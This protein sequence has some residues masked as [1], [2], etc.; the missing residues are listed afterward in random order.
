M[1]LLLFLL[2]AWICRE[3]F[4]IEFIRNLDSNEGVFVSISRFFRENFF[5]QRWYP[6]FNCGMPIENAYQPLLPIWAAATGW[7]TGWSVERAFHFVLAFAYCLG[8]VGLFL[9]A[10]EWSASMVTGVAAGLLYSLT[11]YAQW[12]IPILRI[13]L[14]GHWGPLRLY[15][16]VHY[17]EDPHNV[18]LSLL[19]FALLF[20]WRL[21][22]GRRT[23]G[24]FA[25][26]IVFSGA[27]VATNAFGAVDLAIGALCIILA[28]HRGFVPIAVAGVAAYLWITPWLPPS[29]IGHIGDEQFTSRGLFH[30]AGEALL[31]A[32]AI[33]AVW[34]ALWFLTRRLKDTLDRFSVFFAI[35]M[36]A[37]PIGFFAFNLS[38]VPQGNRYQLELE[39]ALCLLTACIVGVVVRRSNQTIAFTIIAVCMVFAGRQ[40]KHYRDY[41]KTLILSVDITQTVQHKMV[42]W[43]DRNLPG[44][45]AMVAG[46]TEYLYNILSNN[47]QLGGG[48]EPTVPNWMDRVA[49]YTIYTGANAG[50]RDAEFSIFWMKAFG[51]QAITV[52]GE[53]SREAYHPIANP[54]KFDGTLP[55]L[56]H[57]EDDTIF[58]I[59]QRSRSLAHVIPRDAITRRVP[60]HGLDIDPAKP[61]V[62][63]LDDS[64]LPEA[65]IQWQ[66][67][68]HAS[69]AAP[70]KPEQVISVQVSY[71]PGWKASVQERAVPTYADALGLITIEPGCT[72]DCRIELSY[73]VTAEAW[74][75]RALSGMVTLALA[76]MLWQPRTR[77]FR[78]LP[79]DPL[80]AHPQMGRTAS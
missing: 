5:D 12:L 28:L 79:A 20:L 73:G 57:D 45:R 19:P 30:S 37:L 23:N 15:N 31:I 76:A 9:F 43:L 38:L 44:Q 1:S 58:A 22:A 36:C 50:A 34:A 80:P 6:F 40:A 63:A 61:Y 10:W 62:A 46:D 70:M 17:A 27:V 68:T 55:V 65:S 42:T 32:A 4:T 60:I 3:L 69:I 52:P 53:K 67:N 51:V 35:L 64:A 39:M 14:Y 54:H 78:S 21:A 33:L 77:L 8:P 71:V 26:A 48:H 13:R 2:N 49:V 75:C 7:I 47:P 41:A 59:P 16:L 74:V 11:S 18:A 24:N 25:G 56:W 29:L 72:G 66:G